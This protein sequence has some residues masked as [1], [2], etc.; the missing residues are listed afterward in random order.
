MTTLLRLPRSTARKAS[1]AAADVPASAATGAVAN[2]DSAGGVGAL[3]PGPLQDGGRCLRIA[4]GNLGEC[5]A[6]DIALLH[7]GQRDA[8]LE[9]RFRRLPCIGIV[10]VGLEE[11]LGGLPIALLAEQCL[12]K[13]VS[14]IGRARV[15]GV[16]R[17]V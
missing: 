14:R 3:F 13:P 11:D 16:A 12:A 4:P 7:R 2:T 9:E 8:E 5:G 17:D 1:N 10:A 15:T 6:C